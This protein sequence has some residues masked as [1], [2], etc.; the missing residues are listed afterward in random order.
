M[1]SRAQLFC[2]IHF[3]LRIHL[4]KTPSYTKPEDNSTNIA[5]DVDDVVAPLFKEVI[6]RYNRDWQDNLTGADILSWDFHKYIKPD[7]G[8][9]VYEYFKNPDLYENMIPVEGSVAGVQ[10]LRDLGHTVVFVTSC[11]Y[12]MVD[13]KAKW[14]EQQGFCLPPKWGGMLPDDL[15]VATNKHFLTADLLI[16]DAAHTIK[17]WIVE[18]RRRAIMV[19]YPHNASLDLPSMFSPW[20]LRANNWAEI[21]AHVEKLGS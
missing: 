20:L 7:C 9:K 13:Q 6:G 19:Q 12:G 21:V 4:R 16:D 15:I 3:W 14:L 18:T 5:C 17:T 1:E 10:R 11:Y 2:E 8:R